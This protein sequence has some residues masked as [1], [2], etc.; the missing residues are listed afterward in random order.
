LRWI[1]EVSELQKW[2]D[3]AQSKGEV[4]YDEPFDPIM[5]YDD[6]RGKKW[7]Y[8]LSAQFNDAMNS[9]LRKLDKNI[10]KGRAGILG[11][12]SAGNRHR[13]SFMWFGNQL[14]WAKTAIKEQ[15]VNFS[16]YD[17]LGEIADCELGLNLLKYRQGELQATAMADFKPIHDAFC[18]KYNAHINHAWGYPFEYDWS[19]TLKR[20]A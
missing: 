16:D 20:R 12:D 6:G 13:L 15:L 5:I 9:F 2:F 18:A 19:E 11:S 7:P 8:W 14:L 10:P 1:V 4:P 17:L 3:E